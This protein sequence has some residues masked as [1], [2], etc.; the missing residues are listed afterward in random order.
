M[1]I[2]E[3]VTF[4]KERLAGAQKRF[5]LCFSKGSVCAPEG[6][7]FSSSD[8]LDEILNFFYFKLFLASHE[9]SLSV[10]FADFWVNCF[11]TQASI[12]IVGI[13]LRK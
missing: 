9:E 12:A 2:L 6:F 7:F 10:L 4:P 13:F 1:F 8:P 5:L 3:Y 11:E